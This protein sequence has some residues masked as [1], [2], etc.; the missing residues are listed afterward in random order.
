[1]PLTHSVPVPESH[2]P[3]VGVSPSPEET[4][5]PWTSLV[6]YHSSPVSSPILRSPFHRRFRSRHGVPVGRGRLGSAPYS[7]RSLVGI[8][9]SPDPSFHTGTPPPCRDVRCRGPTTSDMRGE[10]TNWSKGRGHQSPESGKT[11]APRPSRC[12]QTDWTTAGLIHKPT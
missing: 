10:R 9:D 4:R 8:G 11:D 5:V 7:P 12:R 2:G 6:V 3:C 1:M